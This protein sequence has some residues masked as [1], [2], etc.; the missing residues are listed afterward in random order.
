MDGKG[1][2]GTG[3]AGRGLGPCLAGNV[4]RMTEEELDQQQPAG[5]NRTPGQRLGNRCGVGRRGGGGRGGGRGQRGGK[6]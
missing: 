6:R 2:L 1:P 3:A 5:S 4:N